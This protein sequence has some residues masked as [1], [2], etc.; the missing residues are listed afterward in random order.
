MG[1]NAEIQIIFPERVNQA[2]WQV[3]SV[4]DLLNNQTVFGTKEAFSGVIL[5]LFAL[6]QR[7]QGY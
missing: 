2:V 3:G 4:K 6:L 1:D 7:K 5:I